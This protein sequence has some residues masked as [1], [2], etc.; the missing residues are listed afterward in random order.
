MRT[1]HVGN[2]SI[3]KDTD[4]IRLP[5]AVKEMLKTWAGQD[6]CSKVSIEDVPHRVGQVITYFPLEDVG[7]TDFSLAVIYA[8]VANSE[9]EAHF[10]T[11]NCK[12][13]RNNVFM[14][15]VVEETQELLVIHSKQLACHLPCNLIST[16]IGDVVCFQATPIV[17]RN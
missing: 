17:F 3:M 13:T 4:R 2:I 12:A 16:A 6:I 11:Y 10:I 14:C 1:E 8:I 7:C 9:N 5:H 15:H